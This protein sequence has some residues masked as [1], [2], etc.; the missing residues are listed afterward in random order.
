MFVFYNIMDTIVQHCV[1]VKVGDVDFIY[2]KSLLTNTR[3]SKVHRQTVYLINI[4][5]SNFWKEGFVMG[6]NVNK[7]NQKEGFAGAYVADPRLV[8]EKPKLR[9]N[10]IASMLCMNCVDFDY[11]ALYPSI[12]DEN[13]MA[14]YTQLGKIIFPQA[15]LERENKFDNAYFDRSVWFIEDLV[16][17]NRLLF[18]HRYFRLADYK[19]MYHDIIEYFTTVKAPWRG[20]RKFDTLTGK[21]IMCEIVPN[22]DYRT[23]CV[24]VDNSKP[25]EMCISRGK[26]PKWEGK[27]KD[28]NNNDFRSLIPQ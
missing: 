3:Y 28:A 2:S 5:T 15:I 19:E 25:R 18:C 10:D 24:I 4:I 7:S 21:R 12:I 9:I 8:S 27:N 14:P 22:K 11:T 6:C 23:M 17:K 16:S 1:E 26:M 13:N 20:L